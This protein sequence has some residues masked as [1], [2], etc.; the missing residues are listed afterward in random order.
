MFLSYFAYIDESEDPKFQTST[1][2]KVYETI[3]RGKRSHVNTDNG[4]YDLIGLDAITYENEDDLV[5]QVIVIL[6][7]WGIRVPN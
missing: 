3:H 6:K 2:I 4:G 7:E 5:D 1:F